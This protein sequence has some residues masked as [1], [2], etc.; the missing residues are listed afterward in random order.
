[1]SQEVTSISYVDVVAPRNLGLVYRLRQRLVPLPARRL[2][3][4]HP[5]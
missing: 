4:D 3:P 1:M 5:E 2:T